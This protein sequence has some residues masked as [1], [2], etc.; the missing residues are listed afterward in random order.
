M[1]SPELFGLHPNASISSA[2]FDCN[3]MI[4][5]IIEISSSVGGGGSDK[6]EKIEQRA[7]EFLDRL[8]ENFDI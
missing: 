7:L 5:S 8:P 4:Q 2:T 1:N 3:F 6:N